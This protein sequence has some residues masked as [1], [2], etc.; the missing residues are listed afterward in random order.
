MLPQSRDIIKRHIEDFPKVGWEMRFLELVI[1]ND[2][3]VFVKLGYD[4]EKVVEMNKEMANMINAIFSQLSVNIALVDVITWSKGDQIEFSPHA[5]DSLEHFLKYR[6]KILL[7]KVRHDL[8]LLLTGAKFARDVSGKAF[9]GSVCDDQN[10]GTIVRYKNHSLLLT[11]AL[12]SHEIGHGFGMKH[13]SSRCKCNSS[14]IMDAEFEDKPPTQW[15]SCSKEVMKKAFKDSDFM[16]LLNKPNSTL[17][18]LCGNGILDANEECDCIEDFCSRCCDRKTCKL[19][20]GAECGTG[21]CCD[22]N[23][24]KVSNSKKV[25]R[26]AKNECDMSDF[27]DGKSEFCPADKYL[28]D[29]HS[30]SGSHCYDGECNSNENQC[31]LLWGSK[32]QIADD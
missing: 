15:S 30:C 29:G 18:S 27:C 17:N 8:A 2:Y 1:V 19:R 4:K 7:P 12:A 16:C 21:E 32:A 24:C 28:P 14:C 5:M 10:A 31:K 3:Q 20:K 13:D 26:E 9:I 23:T 25:C 11:A 6:Q 22:W